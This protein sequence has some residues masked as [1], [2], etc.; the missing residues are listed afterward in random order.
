ML[1]DKLSMFGRTTGPMCERR[2][3]VEALADKSVYEAGLFFMDLR[4]R[5]CP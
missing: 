5:L 4:I 3:Q 2:V 1:Y